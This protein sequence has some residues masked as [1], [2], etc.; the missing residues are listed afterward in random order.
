LIQSVLDVRAQ[1]TSSRG[2]VLV[3]DLGE[4]VPRIPANG[5]DLQ[6]VFVNLITN[7]E[8]AVKDRDRKHVVVSSRL[9]D[10]S[11]RVA[12]SDSGM[13][14]DPALRTRIFDPFFTTK[15]PDIGTGLGLALSQRI[16]TD[17]GGRMWVEDSELGGAC[18][19][20][21]LPVEA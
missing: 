6:Q 18:F 14:V 13:G 20:V 17:H 4:E 7:A 19:V 2:I 5:G 12:V 9:V 21:E 10:G 8:F 15:D 16:A 1:V 3:A 11:I